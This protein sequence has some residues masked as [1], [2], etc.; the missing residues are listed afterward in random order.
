[1]SIHTENVSYRKR[2]YV[3]TLRHAGWT[4]QR[5]ANDQGLA[6]STVYG[7]CNSTANLQREGRCGRHVIIDTPTRR[8]LVFEATC[9]AESRRKP[10]S[11][12]DQEISIQVS[13]KTLRE[14]FTKEG[15]HRR[16]AR[17]KPFLNET[18]RNIRFRFALEHR[19]WTA[20]D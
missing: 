8:M 9:T 16:V 17:K 13:V 4:F 14:A 10:L 3:L 12:I 5:S 2:C 18:Q 11:D 15:Y 7:I 19:N 6:V 1:V 20:E